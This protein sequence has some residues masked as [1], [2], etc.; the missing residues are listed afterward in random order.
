M[1]R[2]GG[3][4]IKNHIFAP[5]LAGKNFGSGKHYF[6]VLI[7]A[8]YARY[9]RP[10]Y[11][12]IKGKYEEVVETS[13]VIF[14]SAFIGYHH[15]NPKHRIFYRIGYTPMFSRSMLHWGGFGVGYKF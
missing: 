11:E 9:K 3:G 7:G 15:H 12:F 5:V 13:H 6:H 14:A 4:T 10:E 2:L 8:T 1:I